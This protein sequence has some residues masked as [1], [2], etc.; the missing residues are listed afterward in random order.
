MTVRNAMSEADKAINGGTDADIQDAL[1]E[2]LEEVE[3][4]MTAIED[5]D[6]WD[7]LWYKGGDSPEPGFSVE[8]LRVL[9]GFDREG[10]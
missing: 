5:Y 10:Q 6:E 1:V 9:L 7:A 3:D 8:K 2:L 4:F